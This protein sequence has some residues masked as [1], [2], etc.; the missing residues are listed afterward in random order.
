M[1]ETEVDSR[2]FYLGRFYGAV[3]AWC[4]AA[5]SGAKKL[6]LSSPFPP[7]D[8]RDVL[9]Y[10]KKAVEENEVQFYLERELMTTDLFHDV[11]MTNKWVFMIYKLDRILEEYLRLKSEKE[12]LEKDGRYSGEIRKDIA[13]RMGALLGYDEDYVNERLRG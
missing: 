8:L 2:N 6:S 9:P 7:E 10:I 13:R 12:Q 11:D 3:S 1:S 4:E 5:R